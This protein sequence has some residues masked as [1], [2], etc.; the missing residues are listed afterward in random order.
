MQF[1]CYVAAQDL[2]AGSQGF[3]KNIQAFGEGLRKA[4]FF[5][6]QDFLNM[7][8]MDFRVVSPISLATALT[9][10]LKKSLRA[11]A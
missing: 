4:N 6:A 1:E 2:G 5:L 7:G 8:I 3:V 11:R 10:L 9:K